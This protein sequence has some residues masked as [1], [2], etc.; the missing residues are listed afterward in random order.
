MNA[1]CDRPAC[2][3]VIAPEGFQSPLQPSGGNIYDRRV[4]AGLAEIGWEVRIGTVR[5]PWPLG[6]RP[7]RKRLARLVESVPD[8]QTLLVDGLIASASAAELLPH[9]ARLRLSVLLHMPLVSAGDRHYDAG[10][11]RSEMAVLAGAASVVVT[12]QWSRRQVL[13]RHGLRPDRVH[14]AQPGVDPADLAD[15]ARF[16]GSGTGRQLLCVATLARHKG[17]DLLV[18]ALAM[19]AEHTVPEWS[20]VLAGPLDPHD[21]FVELLRAR[22]AQGGLSSRIE[23]PGALDAEAL[24]GR[25]HAADL[26]VVPSRSESY[27]MV[28]TEALA[29]GLPV[30]AADV[31]GLPEALGRTADGALPGRLIPPDD[32]AALAA[33]LDQWL[34]DGRSRQQLKAAALVR[35]STLTSWAHTV[36]QLAAALHSTVDGARVGT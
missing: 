12:S 18:D 14:V 1:R 25:Y 11:I 23:L 29:R 34:R 27:G 9:A 35:R 22:I 10:T 17:Q 6:D 31:G 16:R 20:C 5:G 28:V 21:P 36:D 2:V 15:T 4:C 3:T 7:A 8:G 32:P 24:E 30:F 13:T 26:L 33:G 19:L